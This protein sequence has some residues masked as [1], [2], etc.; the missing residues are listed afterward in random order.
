MKR[1]GGDSDTETDM[2]GGKIMCGDLRRG[3]S[4]TNQGE[5]RGTDCP[6]EPSKEPMLLTP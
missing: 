1:E 6:L 2:P 4:S 3:Q 5:T